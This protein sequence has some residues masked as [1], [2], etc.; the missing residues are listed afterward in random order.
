[1][2]EEIRTFIAIN[3]SPEVREQTERLLSQ[4][5][6]LASPVKWETPQNMHMTLK[7]LGDLSGPQ[8]VQVKAA[9][10]DVGLKHVSVMLQ[11]TGVGAFPSLRRPR[12]LWAGVTGEVE[13]LIQI[14]KALDQA[15]AGCGFPLEERPFHP[16][17][18][19]GRVKEPRDVRIDP[20]GIERL[21]FQSEKFSICKLVV[22]KSELTPRGAIYTPQAEYPL[23]A[24]Q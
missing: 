10:R 7:F 24:V 1:M 9:V 19:L 15:L 23:S 14:Q 11:L 18:T 20:H 5:K 13:A 22:M 21:P 6:P 3:I 4:L 12:V 16:H 2:P 17:L 8:V